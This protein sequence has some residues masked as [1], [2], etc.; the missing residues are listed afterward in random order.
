V[1][2]LRIG[3]EARDIRKADIPWNLTFLVDISGSMTDRLA[4]VRKSL[5]HL[6]DAM[7]PGDRISI[8]TYAGG[9][10]TVLEPTTLAQRD[11][12]SIKGIIEDL[13]PGGGTA[14]ADGLKNAYA[15]NRM[16]F[17]DDGVNRVIVCSD[18]DANIGATGWDEMLDQVKAYKEQGITLSTLGFGIGNFNDA[19]MEM[20]ADR[21]NGN[22]YYIDSEAEAERLFTEELTA[23]MQVVAW[24]AKIQVAFRQEAVKSYRLLGYE[25]R[26]IADS[27]FHDDTTD[28]GE[29]G[30]GHTVTALYELVLAKP[31][32][33]LGAVH[34]RYRDASGA[35][36]SVSRDLGSYSGS[37]FSAAS[38]DFRFA[39]TVAEYAEILRQSPYVDTRLEQVSAT[40]RGLDKGGDPKRSEFAGIVDRAA[41]LKAGRPKVASR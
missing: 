1:V 16:G 8:A 15:V 11:K 34:L 21:G 10:S 12:A 29:V 14:M 9:V 27:A 41:G 7:R 20:L 13:T 26:A 33:P 24:D 32:A 35:T 39:F 22:Y 38:P 17:L 6:V 40:L 28:A 4:L 31:S 18:G 3:L 19:T 37:A 25:N 30:A 23:M 36:R 2:G 5:D